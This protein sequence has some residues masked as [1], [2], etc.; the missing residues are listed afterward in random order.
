MIRAGELIAVTGGASGLG[1]A[2][3]ERLLEEGAAVLALDLREPRLTHPRLSFAR[4]DVSEPEALS[5]AL[6][7]GIAKA[8]VLRGLVSCAGILHGERVLGRNG[9]HEL[10]SF[11]RVVQVNLTG[12]FNAARLAAERIARAEPG[13]DGARGV[14]VLTASIAAWEGQVGQAAYAASKGGVAGLVLPLAR[15]LGRHG[16]RVMG[17]APGLM[18]TPMV[19]EMSDEARDTMTA[20]IPFPPRLGKGTEFAALVAHIL[21]NDLLNGEIIRLDGGLRLQ[22]R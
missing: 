8:G 3:A 10:D 4:V 5:A 20:G 2:V 18:E 7:E 9:A 1:A 19:A 11:A 13:A 15:E 16:I 12:S 14:I 21:D 6:D 17:I 22:A